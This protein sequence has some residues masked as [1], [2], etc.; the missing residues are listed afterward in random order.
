MNYHDE[1]DRLR[2]DFAE[3]SRLAEERLAHANQLQADIEADREGRKALRLRFGA[4]DDE[5][6][7]AFI[8]RLAAST[9]ARRDDDIARLTRER[10]RARAEVDAL[11]AVLDNVRAILDAHR[12]AA[13]RCPDC[14]CLA[15]RARRALDGQSLPSDA[16]DAARAAI[17]DE[18]T[19]TRAIIT[20]L[21]RERDEARA[22]AEA[23]V[24]V[25]NYVRTILDAHR[26]AACRCPGCRARR[27]MDGTSLPCDAADAAR[28]LLVRAGTMTFEP[29]PEE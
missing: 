7:G 4:R 27:A 5:T 24:G 29:K 11:L 3:V 1:I 14:P 18:M 16:A 8:G 2:K 10:D 23:L 26:D 12:D 9:D 25:L 13:C 20:R 28:D 6:M 21:T 22:E 19:M 15:C 17:S